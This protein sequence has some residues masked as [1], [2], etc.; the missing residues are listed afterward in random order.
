MS[1]RLCRGNIMYSHDVYRPEFVVTLGLT[2]LVK[3]NYQKIS[4]CFMVRRAWD[5]FTDTIN[6]LLGIGGTFRRFESLYHLSEVIGKPSYQ[7]DPWSG[8]FRVSYQLTWPSGYAPLTESIV[9]G[10]IKRLRLTEEELQRAT[11]PHWFVGGENDDEYGVK[12]TVVH[13]QVIEQ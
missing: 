7:R 6:R 10:V 11:P 5:R 8:L 9:T 12:A 2:R 13:G 1:R 3:D 4:V